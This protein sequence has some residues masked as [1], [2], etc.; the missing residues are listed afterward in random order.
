MKI[1]NIIAT[2]IGLLSFTMIASAADLA[3]TTY[4]VTS[5]K[6]SAKWNN[7]PSGAAQALKANQELPEGAIISTAD[8]SSVILLFPTGTT[9]VIGEKSEVTVTKLQQEPF[10]ATAVSKKGESSISAIEIKLTKG[11]I[12]S[13]VNKL[14]SQSTYVIKTPVGVAGVRGTTFQVSYDPGTK[15]LKVLTAEG[16]V[17]FTTIANVDIPVDGGQNIVI[18]VDIDDQGVITIREVIQ[19]TLSQEEINLLL[20][21][22][23]VDLP[24][25]D[26][27][28]VPPTD[29]QPILSDD[30]P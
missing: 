25:P 24:R 13:R 18:N 28:P 20:E 8:A 6:G 12:A 15:V 23:P 5:I 27:V 7:P 26:P 17:V 4:R 16:Q 9:A 11:T 19:G 30:K 29:T 1:L 3:A 22:F 14:R 2:I 21:D 10:A